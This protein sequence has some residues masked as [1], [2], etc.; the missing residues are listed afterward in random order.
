MPSHS[1]GGIDE[2]AIPRNRRAGRPQREWLG[3]SR[4]HAGQGATPPPIAY[5][6]WSGIYLGLSLG[7]VWAEVDRFYPHFELVHLV[8]QTFTSRNEDGIVGFH[9]GAQWQWGPWVIGFEVAY[10]KGWRDISGT[11]SLSPPNRSPR[12]APTTRSP[13]C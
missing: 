8:P 2:K 13:A 7:G 6:D 9:G 4:R 5:Y 3:T 11:V 1:Q 12:W 10:G